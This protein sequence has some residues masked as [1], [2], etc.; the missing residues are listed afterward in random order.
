MNLLRYPF[1]PLLAVA[2]PILSLYQRNMGKMEFSEV[3]VPLAL[4]SLL[5]VVIW[6]CAR[7]F[8]R[9]RGAAPLIALIMIV[10]FATYNPSFKYLT[11]HGVGKNPYE[12]HTLLLQLQGGAFILLST[13]VALLRRRIFWTIELFNIASICLVAGVGYSIVTGDRGPVKIANRDRLFREVEFPQNGTIER[14][15]IYYILLDAYGRQDVLKDLGYLD[16]TP[17]VEGLRKLGFFVADKAV[18]NYAQTLLSLSSTLN[19]IHLQ[20][21]AELVG[22]GRN[23]R[24]PLRDLVRD[25]RVTRA[26]KSL[27]YRFV[28]FSSGYSGTDMENVDEERS[29]PLSLSEF[30]N[31]ILSQSPVPQILRRLPFDTLKNWQFE[32]HRM[33]INHIFDDLSTLGG[34]GGPKF[35][36]VHL[37]SP[38]PPFVF[39]PHGEP[40][41]PVRNFSFNDASHY[42]KGGSPSEYIHGYGRQAEYIGARVLDTVTSILRKDPGAVIVIQGDHG[43]GGHLSWGSYLKSNMR[44]RMAI[45]N[46]YHVPQR[47]RERLSDS[48]SPVNSFRIILS[49]LFGARLDP[50]PDRAYFSRWHLPYSFRDVTDEVNVLDKKKKLRL[51]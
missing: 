32:A 2:Y 35:V 36:F 11:D 7:F 41:N 20:K 43:P 1:Y 49:T 14:P 30:Q 18:A 39:G 16:N 19:M 25:N 33:R 37:I 29:S 42:V 28:S 27:G 13:V 44:E 50:L 10:A 40:V 46:A 51:E 48:T 3:G 47:V 8:L 38:H 26:L 12:R 17:F 22:I 24:A 15:D 34:E 6:G 23:E 45:L 31:L 21:V 5:A 9:A 4:F